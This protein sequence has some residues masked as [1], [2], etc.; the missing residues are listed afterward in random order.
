MG[1]ADISSMMPVAISKRWI[2]L[3][4]TFHCLATLRS[5]CRESTTY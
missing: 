2:N 5:W 1:E 3:K 4:G